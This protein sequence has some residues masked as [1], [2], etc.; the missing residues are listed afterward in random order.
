M[1]GALYSEYIGIPILNVGQTSIGVTFTILS[2]DVKLHP[3]HINPPFKL[4]SGQTTIFPLRI[5]MDRRSTT[6]NCEGER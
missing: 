3:E 4:A 6:D 5:A 2:T 1:D